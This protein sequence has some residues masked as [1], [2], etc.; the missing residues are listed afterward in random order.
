MQRDP[1]ESIDGFNLYE[2][3]VSRPI[4]NIDPFGLAYIKT[5]TIH[6]HFRH[7]RETGPDPDTNEL[8]GHILMHYTVVLTYGCEDSDLGINTVPAVYGLAVTRSNLSLERLP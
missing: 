8:V 4:T 3:V 2:Y 7:D 6:G 5:F 1:L